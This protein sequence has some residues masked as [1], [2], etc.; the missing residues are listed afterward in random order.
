MQLTEEGSKLLFF[1]ELLSPFGAPQ[2]QMPTALAKES[3][4]ES[5]CARSTQTERKGGLGAE[6]L[7]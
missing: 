2:W 6:Q 4:I 7:V 1:P 5:L 3:E